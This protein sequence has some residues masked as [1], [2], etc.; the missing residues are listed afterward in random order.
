MLDP[1]I[2]RA[3]F[4]PAALA[5]ILAAFSLEPRPGPLTTT[6][7]A[8]AF[9]GPRA[10]RE[11]RE[12]AQ[13][14]PRR[15]AG[16]AADAALAGRVEAS[17][18]EAGFDTSHHV[19]QG[20]TVSG[21]R[22]LSTVVG[23]R[24]G[25]SARR[26]LV[27]AHRD[28]ANG[29]AAAELSGTVALLELARVFAGRKL[30][31][32]LVLASTSGGGAGVADLAERAG[33]GVDAAL[34]LGD[35]A[36][37]RLR[38][39]MVVPW[40][41]GLGTAPLVL[42]RTV[43]EAVRAETGLAP[44]APGLAAQLARHA[45]PLTTGEQGE[46]A[47]RAVPAVLLGVSGELGSGGSPDVSAGRFAA[48]GR[49][50]LRA[51][52]ALDGAPSLQRRPRAEL[53]ARRNVVPGWAIRLLVGALLLPVLVAVVDALARARR[54]REPVGVWFGWIAACAAPF[55]LVWLFARLAALT[56][57]IGASQG[58]PVAADATALDGAAR[59]V[60]AAA[61]AVLLLGWVVVRPAITRL[62]GVRGDLSSGG[63]AAAA[64]A[65]MCAVTAGVWL[66]NPFAAAMLLPALHL[67]TLATLTGA[68]LRRPAALAVPLVGLAPL[69][70]LAVHY[71]AALE[72]GPASAAWHA[73]LLAAG[74]HA[75]P[76][77][78][79]ALAAVLGS[80]V[81]V[82]AVLWA[83][84]SVEVASPGVT[85]GGPLGYPGP[86]SLGGT[87]SGFARR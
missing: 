49:A 20:R 85:P 47:A 2:Y 13:L 79:V 59:G 77:T 35:L 5:V 45:Y 53:V 67:W 71:A 58:A 21:E 23:V 70:G 4:L 16:G 57:V 8:D 33:G 27:L 55:L 75:G 86:G 50:T 36:G 72:L 87:Q 15:R 66:S 22:E 29:P 56:G 62:A 78:A 60:L 82:A 10:A 7:T 32:T 44:G 14:F 30:R 28:A 1:R 84:A 31:R 80:A 81:A 24:V 6:L 40:S 65:T 38:R 19:F 41:N 18:R 37:P 61:G 63:P 68:R 54:R 3:A 73:L 46:L 76:G 51:L 69:L 11:L 48:F 74:G 42:R 26:L 52:T 34:V 25:S 9:E 17:F 12:L 64:A 43:E 83:R 39:P